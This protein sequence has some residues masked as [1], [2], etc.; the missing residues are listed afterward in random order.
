MNTTLFVDKKTLVEFL[1]AAKKSGGAG[2]ADVVVEPH[3]QRVGPIRR[4]FEDFQ[5]SYVDRWSQVG[6]NLFGMETVSVSSAA[7][8]ETDVWGMCYLGEDLT[9]SPTEHTVVNTI[10]RTALRAVSV[11]APFRGPVRKLVRHY[12]YLNN[13]RGGPED[14]SGQER[15]LHP[16]GRIVWWLE[17][18]GKSALEVQILQSGLA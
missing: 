7:I 5:L 10:L 13:P 3:G 12:E 2:G 6:R 1:V 15:I 18:F 8:D 14:F 11:D 9:R 4:Q 17:Y 16:S